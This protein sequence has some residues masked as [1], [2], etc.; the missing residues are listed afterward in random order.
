[1]SLFSRKDPPPPV[2]DVS[3]KDY[4]A[5]CRQLGR[6]EAQVESIVLTWHNYR[7]QITRLV[8]RLE[9]REQRLKAKDAAQ[10]E[11]QN[12]VDPQLANLDP[13]SRRI[14]L[15][16]KGNAISRHGRHQPAG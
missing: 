8:Q 2:V 16:R 7:E 4:T 5:L 1:M 9:K 3:L 15:R 13:I 14:H 12:G 6:L 10:D 11:A